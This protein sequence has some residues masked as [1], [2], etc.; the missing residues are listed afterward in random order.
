MDITTDILKDYCKDIRDAYMSINPNYENSRVYIELEQ[1]YNTGTVNGLI[2]KNT[3]QTVKRDWLESMARK[4]N[5][6]YYDHK[7]QIRKMKIH[8][9]K[10]CNNNA[11]K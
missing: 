1:F 7:A 5:V 8:K 9:I 2:Y 10:N 6:F 4:V 3:K 11:N